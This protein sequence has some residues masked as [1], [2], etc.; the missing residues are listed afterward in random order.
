MSF[1]SLVERLKA[2]CWYI[3]QPYKSFSLGMIDRSDLLTKRYYIASFWQSYLLSSSDFPLN[4]SLQDNQW[5]KLHLE[6][7]KVTD[8]ACVEKAA[9]FRVVSISSWV[10]EVLVS[11]WLY[12]QRSD[13][14]LSRICANKF[15][16]VFIRNMT[17]SLSLIRS[18]FSRHLALILYTSTIR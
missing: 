3:R 5:F 11:R 1:S 8:S 17:V 6:H 10:L 15:I 13:E 9:V 7:F 4:L 18:N 2:T 16:D 12:F 14:L